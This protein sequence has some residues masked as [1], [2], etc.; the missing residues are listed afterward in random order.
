MSNLPPPPPPPPPGAGRGSKRPAAPERPTPNHDN[1][2][3]GSGSSGTDGEERSGLPRW[4]WWIIGAVT[5]LALLATSLWPSDE[6]EPREY[7][8][9]IE[10]VEDGNISTAEVNTG[11]G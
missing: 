4:G 9:F 3:K 11:T 8:A 7:T 2:S 1:E 5:V 10:A 6:G